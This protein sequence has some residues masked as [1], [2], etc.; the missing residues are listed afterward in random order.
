MSSVRLGK[1]ELKS[2]PPMLFGPTTLNKPAAVFAGSEVVSSDSADAM[3]TSVVMASAM[4]EAAS[5]PATTLGLAMPSDVS[6]VSVAVLYSS[7][8]VVSGFV[9]VEVKSSSFY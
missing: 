1:S 2:K 7:V 9:V 6:I 3:S 8:L 5:V 4:V